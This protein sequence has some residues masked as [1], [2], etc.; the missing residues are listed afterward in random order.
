MHVWAHGAQTTGECGRIQEELDRSVC[1]ACL[2]EEIDFEGW[3]SHAFPLL[4]IHLISAFK[5]LLTIP[6]SVGITWRLF[7][8]KTKE[9][10]VP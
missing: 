2:C 7:Q 10:W 3:P 1:N 6:G 8:D 5:S 4:P 9:I